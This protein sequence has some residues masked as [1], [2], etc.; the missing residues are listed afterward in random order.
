MCFFFVANA[1]NDQ[2]LQVYLIIDLAKLTSYIQ[3][4]EYK[5]T[6]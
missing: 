5:K 6:H 4:I 2:G 1:V 3:A